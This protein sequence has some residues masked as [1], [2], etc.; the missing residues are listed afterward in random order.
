L[1]LLLLVESVLPLLLEDE[2]LRRIQGRGLPL[3][4]V[5]RRVLNLAELL[6]LLRVLCTVVSE[7]LLLLPP[8]PLPILCLPILSTAPIVLL[9]RD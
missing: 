9:W 4:L 5:L 6:K 2:L 7:L 8:L 1:V 3:T